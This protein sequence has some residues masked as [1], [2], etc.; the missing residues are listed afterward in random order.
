MKYVDGTKF[1]DLKESLYKKAGIIQNLK[2]F[3]LDCYYKQKYIHAD[4]HNGNWKVRYN[5]KLQHY[6]I[7][8]Y[9]YGLCYNSS[10]FNMFSLRETLSEGNIELLT[11]H[12]LDL[13]L[14]K[15]IGRD[16]AKYSLYKQRFIKIMEEKDYIDTMEFTLIIPM[17]YR[18]TVDNN[19][20]I[21]GNVLLLLLL[22]LVN[23]NNVNKLREKV[24][25]K[26]NNLENYDY[27]R[28]LYY[29]D[30][31]NLYP[32]LRSHVKKYI[33][34][35]QTSQCLFNY[36]DQKYAHLDSSDSD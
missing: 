28:M 13:I 25:I 22:M 35:H 6:Q 10:N 15:S 11:D 31:N 27:P 5:D 17:I 3:S 24:S 18:F 19:L 8:I 36:I 26:N 21:N 23:D 32:E 12:V 30:K 20:K 4:L 1:D 2:L 9:D 29:C 33:D 34:K 14:D 7:I 16:T